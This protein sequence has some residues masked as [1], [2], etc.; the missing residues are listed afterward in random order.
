MGIIMKQITMAHGAGGTIMNELIKNYPT[1]DAEIT[2]KQFSI[3]QEGNLDVEFK[4]SHLFHAT[5]G[6]KWAL[7]ETQAWGKKDSGIQ[8]FKLKKA[9]ISKAKKLRRFRKRT[10]LKFER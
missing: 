2:T 10:Q 1:L 7:T 9:H 8:Q 3:S 4:V 6:I 5:S